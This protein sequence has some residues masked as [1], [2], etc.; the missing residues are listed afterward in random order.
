MLR[1]AVAKHQG[2]LNVT[3]QRGRSAFH[4]SLA[5]GNYSDPGVLDSLIDWRFVRKKTP[6]TV[7]F[8]C[9]RWQR[10]VSEKKLPLFAMS[11]ETFSPNMFRL[12]KHS[13]SDTWFS[14]HGIFMGSRWFGDFSFLGEF[15]KQS[16][17]ERC[18]ICG[19]FKETPGTQCEEG[20]LWTCYATHPWTP[21]PC[22]GGGSL[23]LQASLHP[24]GC[25]RC[26]T[27]VGHK[28]TAR[29]V[30]IALACSLKED[31]GEE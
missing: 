2:L 8:C 18:M 3:H 21:F 25:L 4:L 28:F 29:R 12:G 27:D 22:L 30:Y 11:C 20:S 17:H 5:L 1:S 13:R 26:F 24:R 9:S 10:L 31:R 14:D 6:V 23:A 15:S 16:V 19:H 7:A